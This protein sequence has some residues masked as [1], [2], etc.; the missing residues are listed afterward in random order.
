MFSRFVGATVAVAVVTAFT[1]SR[2]SYA[3]PKP[4]SPNSDPGTWTLLFNGKD[5]TGFYTFIKTPGKNNDADEYF[6][7]ENGAIHVMSFP[8]T[9][10]K[11]DFGYIRTD[12]EYDNYHLRFQ[13]KWGQKKHLPRDKAKRD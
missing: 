9:E 8:V 10:N 11:R 6:K 7:V 3:Q 13:Y 1:S 5:L 12:K 2:F 4:D